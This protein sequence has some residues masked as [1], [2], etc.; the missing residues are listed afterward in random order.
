MYLC[1]TADAPRKCHDTEE[2]P[3]K[4]ERFTGFVKVMRM[5]N[6]M[7][8]L[9]KGNLEELRTRDVAYICIHVRCINFKHD[10]AYCHTLQTLIF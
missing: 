7:E 8:D 10:V 9:R 1:V 6:I 2:P 4:P 5:D 3:P